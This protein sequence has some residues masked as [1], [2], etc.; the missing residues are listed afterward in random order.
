MR[1]MREDN[2]EDADEME[3]LQVDVQAVVV[4]HRAGLWTSK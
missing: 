2:A 3:P 1:R 4:V